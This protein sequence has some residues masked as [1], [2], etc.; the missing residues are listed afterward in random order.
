MNIRLIVRFRSRN[1]KIVID[2]LLKIYPPSIIWSLPKCSSS[3]R[4]I[5]NIAHIIICKLDTECQQV[6]TFNSVVRNVFPIMGYLRSKNIK[7]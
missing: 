1:F 2:I 5:T 3:Q 4:V 6:K 7:T